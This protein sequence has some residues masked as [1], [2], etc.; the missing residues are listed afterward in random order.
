MSVTE[1]V[2]LLT[3]NYVHSKSSTSTRYSDARLKSTSQPGIKSQYSM[4]VCVS[5]LKLLINGGMMWCL[6]D[7]LNKF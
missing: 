5:S 4:C 6:C 1:L 2:K 3:D 7:W